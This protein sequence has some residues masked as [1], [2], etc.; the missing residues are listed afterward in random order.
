MTRCVN[1]VL[2]L[3]LSSAFVWSD[4]FADVVDFEELSLEPNSFFDGY[5]AG[6]TTGSWNSGPLEFNTNQFGPG[7][8]YSN[9]N[10]STTAGFTNQWA[11]ITETGFGGDG[12]YAVANSLSEN[13]AWINLDQPAQ[14]QSL[15]ATNTTFAA[16]SIRDGDDFAKQFGGESGDDPD[17]FKVIFT[18]FSDLAATGT[19]TGSVEFFL[20]DF[21]SANNDE[22]FI[23]DDWFQVDLSQLG[24]VSSIGISFESSDTGP[25]G[26]NTPAYVAIDSLTLIGIPE[27]GSAAC[28]VLLGLFPAGH[29]RRKR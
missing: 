2:L 27:P 24:N 13:G 8:S 6:A 5:G 25:F 4:G 14:I 29:R 9:V 17:F 12:I 28:L 21:R 15:W 10:D 11:A 3:L 18:G 22:D 26:I 7:W 1:T 23:V 20:A 19:S 16:L